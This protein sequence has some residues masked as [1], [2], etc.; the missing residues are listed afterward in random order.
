MLLSSLLFTGCIEDVDINT[1]YSV[2]MDDEENTLTV[3]SIFRDDIAWSDIEIQGRYTF[4]PTHTYVHIGDVISECKGEITCI[5]LPL[6]DILGTWEFTEPLDP[7][8]PSITF[9]HN[10]NAHTITVTSVD[11]Y[12][13]S[14]ITKDWKINTDDLKAIESHYGTS[15]DPG[16]IREDTNKDGIIDSTDWKAVNNLYGCV[17][18]PFTWEDITVGE[19]DCTVPTGDITVN[20]QL[21]LCQKH[22]TVHWK[23]T[24]EQLGSCTFSADIPPPTTFNLTF[25]QNYRKHKLIV[26]Q[27]NNT[28]FWDDIN[29]AGEAITTSLGSHVQ[30]GDTITDCYG[31]INITFIPNNVQIGNWTFLENINTPDIEFLKD[32]QENT[33]TVTSVEFPPQPRW[34]E[35]NISGIATTDYLGTYVKVG[36]QI[37]NCSRLITITYLPTNITLELWF[38]RD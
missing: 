28:L 7:Y 21:T 3:T 9:H 10:K 14:D 11:L 29:I 1:L 18:G 22:V 16:W 33:L 17:Y 27:V 37:T 26:T 34:N 19:S 5:F 13:P 8:T 4:E 30:I 20:D 36:D 6:G 32:D 23:P 15:N 35:F 2:T 12:H 38:F 25:E 24:A 31:R